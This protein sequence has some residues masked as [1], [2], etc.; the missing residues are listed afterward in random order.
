ME[1]PAKKPYD[2]FKGRFTVTKVGTHTVI[3]D[4]QKSWEIFNTFHTSH[5]YKCESCCVEGRP[6]VR[7][8]EGDLDLEPYLSRKEEVKGCDGD[9][10]D[11]HTH[12]PAKPGPP[13]AMVHI[14]N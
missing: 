6:L 2:K 13:D 7:L 8:R 3:I 4:L 11:F 10:R 9:I 1:R 14:I 12:N 5:S